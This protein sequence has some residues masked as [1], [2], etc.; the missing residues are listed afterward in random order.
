MISETVEAKRAVDAMSRREKL[1]KELKMH[2]GLGAW[3]SYVILFGILFAYPFILSGKG[4]QWGAY[5]ILSVLF[6]VLL[7]L[8]HRKLNSVISLLREY[9]GLPSQGSGGNA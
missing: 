8:L 3:V 1:W 7:L 9:A 2:S 6:S 5:G 4:S